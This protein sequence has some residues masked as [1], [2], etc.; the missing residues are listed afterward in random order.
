MTVNFDNSATTFPKPPEVRL[1]VEKAIVRYGSSGRGSHPIAV[2][3]SELIYSARETIAN[4]LG[5][6][7]ENVV[8]TANC[9]HALNIAIQGIAKQGG[10]VIISQLEH[11]SVLRPVYA[12]AKAGKIKYSIATVTEKKSETLENFAKLIRSDTKAI[13]CT[14]A[15]NVTGQ[16]LP[17]KEIGALC[18]EKNICFI[19]DG[20]QACGLL[21]IN[22]KTDNINFLCT[23]GHKALYG[24][25]GT[26]LLI[27]D[28][29]FKLPPLMH[30]G[31]GSMSNLP[32]MPDFLPDS[33]EAG[34]LNI[35]GAASLKAGIAFV[36]KKGLQN[37]FKSE[38][39]L[40][41]IF[42]QKLAKNPD[43]II[44]RNP[45]ANYV[46]IVSFNLKNRPAEEIA[47]ELGKKGFC[48]R[49]GL[50]CA[51]LAHYF[52]KT[53]EIYQGTVRFAPSVFSNIQDTIRLT[54]SILNL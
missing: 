12:L 26:G 20:A 48:L 21:P 54:D 44:Y 49:A 23:A 53:T 32:E 42:C 1:A 43:I 51:P 52:M 46:P 7:P 40:C 17:W 9:T 30:G 45:E 37:I 33:L 39:A 16:I 22:L 28:G 34:T 35:I 47:L 25:T 19:A 24:I 6:E 31:S 13:I 29:K 38:T 4:F 50:H 10:H 15:S 41:E 8:L 14:I 2:R 36:Q 18:Q 5:A 27:S 11:N 3:G